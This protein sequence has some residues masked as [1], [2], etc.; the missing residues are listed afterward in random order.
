MSDL[1]IAVPSRVKCPPDWR[2]DDG[3]VGVLQ[4]FL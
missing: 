1:V 2:R 4:L 3:I